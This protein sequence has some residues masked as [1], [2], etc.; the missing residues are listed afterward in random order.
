MSSENTVAPYGGC[1]CP[2]AAGRTAVSVS[3]TLLFFAFTNNIP[4]LEEL[5]ELISKVRKQC[6]LLSEHRSRTHSHHCYMLTPNAPVKFR[7]TQ[8]SFL[9]FRLLVPF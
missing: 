2:G 3:S 6:T 7:H 4:F 8:G 9:L 1:V 5:I